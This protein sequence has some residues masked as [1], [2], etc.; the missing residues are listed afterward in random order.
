MTRESSD[1]K[2]AVFW[3]CNFSMNTTRSFRRSVGRSVGWSI[4][5]RDWDVC[6]HAREKNGE[7][8]I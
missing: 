5:H 6:K 3:K 7:V 4:G 1:E 2:K 8:N